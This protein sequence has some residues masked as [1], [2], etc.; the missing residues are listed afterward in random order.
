MLD[1]IVKQDWLPWTWVLVLGFPL[2]IVLL[3]EAIVRLERRKKPLVVPLR[4]LRNFVLPTL[5]LFLLLV[6]VLQLDSKTTSVR[7]VETL[8]WVF[9]IY[10]ALT[11]I[12]IL[13]F[14]EAKPGSWQSQTPKLFLDLS[15][16][17]LVLVGT[18]MVLSTVWKAN[19]AGF[20]TALG[21]GS[22]VIGLALQDS[23]GNVFSGIALLFERPIAVGDW[24]QIGDNTG[25][26][27][28]VTW[29]SVH[30][31]T[32]SRDLL[33]VPNS[34]LAK[35]KLKNLSR[36]ALLHQEIFEIGFSY[37]DPPN[38]VKQVLKQTALETEGVLSEPAP[39]VYL[40]TY[41]D[42]YI[43]YKVGL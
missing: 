20:L 25:K 41:S 40:V 6:K 36:P 18:A 5:A 10:T 28:E 1:F 33:V 30:L 31:R 11:A 13:L 14:E 27:I 32:W 9:I 8:L 16:F 34:E 12:N 4:T 43:S 26:V 3:G 23:L 21:V 19:L 39:W 29:R 42:Y 7:L 15:R 22:V 17:F 2:S 38:K 24:V 37:D 35:S